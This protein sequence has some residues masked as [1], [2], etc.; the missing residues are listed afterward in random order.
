MIG[1]TAPL[2]SCSVT[3]DRYGIAYL[4]KIQPD[5]AAQAYYQLVPRAGG[6]AQGQVVT[7]TVTLTGTSQDGTALP[8][9]TNQ[10]DLIGPP[11]GPQA[12]NIVSS[13]PNLTSFPAS[14]AAA[15]P[16]AAT[17]QLI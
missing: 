11:V 2:G 16:G 14:S 8:S 7:V 1:D 10:F 15:D 9:I 3:L 6:I 12:A 17:V 13:P 4:A 5:N